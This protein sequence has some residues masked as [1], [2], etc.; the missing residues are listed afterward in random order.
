MANGNNQEE[1]VKPSEMNA[2]DFPENDTFQDEYTRTFMKSIEEVDSGYYEFR[3][4]TNLYEMWLPVHST[5]DE[6]LYS[7]EAQE[8]FEQFLGN[9]EN[10]NESFSQLQVTFDH[11]NTIDSVER[12][13]EFLKSS[14]DKELEF[15]EVSSDNKAIFIAPLEYLEEE[16]Y[17][18]TM[19]YA[20][21]VQ[22]EEGNGSLELVYTTF[23]SEEKKINCKAIVDAEKEKVIKITSS[24]SFKRSD[25]NI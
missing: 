25:E 15:E 6:R 23:C 24:V 5:L 18:E 4:G 2:E 11:H 12:N 21:L 22:N 14:I 13:L 19:G 16:G 7:L 10:D 17:G 9:I 1:T 3:S 8:N 20:A